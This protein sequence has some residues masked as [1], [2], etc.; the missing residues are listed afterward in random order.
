MA[1]DVLIHRSSHSEARSWRTIT[2]LAGGGGLVR[3]VVVL[4]VCVSDGRR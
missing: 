2:T 3:G 1:M 4:R